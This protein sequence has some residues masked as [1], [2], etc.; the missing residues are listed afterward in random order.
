[1]KSLL[2]AMLF[3]AGFSIAL[4]AQTDLETYMEEKSSEKLE[5]RKEDHFITELFTDLWQEI[6]EDL[7]VR[8]FNRGFNS[9]FM[10]DYPIAKTNFAIGFGLG[11]SYHNLHSNG[12]L[13]REVDETLGFTGETEFNIIAGDYRTNKLTLAYIDMP[14]EIRFR[15]KNIL[16]SFKVAIGFKAGYNIK[17]YTKYDGDL[18]DGTLDKDGEVPKIKTKEYDIEHIERFRYG[19]TTRIG[20]GKINITAYYSLTPLM[21]KNKSKADKMFPIS[22]GIAFTPF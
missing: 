15:T 21:V 5:L 7:D 10:Y 2:F 16:N 6:P 17:N 20:Y 8:I 13:K 22:V 1:M 3:Y 11:L 12:I 14:V 9:Y 18:L 19:I 4:I